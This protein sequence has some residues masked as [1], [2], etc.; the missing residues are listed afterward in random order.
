MIDAG[1][2]GCDFS[3]AHFYDALDKFREA[4]YVFGSPTKNSEKSIQI[5]HDVDFALEPAL[6][7]ARL[8]RAIGLRT[9]YFIRS[10]SKNYNLLSPS[11][12]KSVRAI[13]SLGHKVGLHY[14]TQ[15]GVKDDEKYEAIFMSHLEFLR[16]ETGLELRAHNVHEPSRTGSQHHTIDHGINYFFRNK[17]WQ[18]YKYISDS[19]GRW[20]EGC[21]CRFADHPRLLVLIHPIWWYETNPNESY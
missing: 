19:G 9:I 7:M 4:D 18:T 2:S 1:N 21:F 8:E 5:V 13:E 11:T 15:T 3:Y 17:R 12:I 10:R 16:S 6:E 14:E 20:R